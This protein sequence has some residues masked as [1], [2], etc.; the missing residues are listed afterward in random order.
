MA[1]YLGLSD[2]AASWQLQRN[3]TSIKTNLSEVGQKLTTG[4]FLTKDISDAGNIQKLFAIDNSLEILERYK[5]STDAGRVRLDGV[6][7]ILGQ[8]RDVAANVGLGV[9]TAVESATISTSLVEA[10][11]AGPA[12]QTIVGLLNTNVAGHSLFS[13]AASD[14]AALASSDQIQADIDA[15]VAAAPDVATA[16]ADIDFY[17]ND[18]TGGFETTIYT[19]SLIDA[20][21]IR[22]SETEVISVPIRADDQALRETLR[23]LSVFA[24][25]A[26]GGF[27][28]SPTQQEAMLLDAATRNLSASDD[29]IK[30]RE[31]TG[32]NQERLEE[33]T[34][35]NDAER[36]GLMISR[37]DIAN[38]DQY[39]MATMFQ[40]LQG[41][42]E[43][44]Y[45]ITARLSGLTLTNFLR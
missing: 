2:L 1:A 12:M 8:V 6:Q 24:A 39:E 28:G 9:L 33:A 41:Q 25:V 37:V 23:N 32:F 42:L 30:L 44:M 35:R 27:A 18:P 29:V 17:F 38:V 14:R 45:A 36:S 22:L 16:L 21:D 7:S 19:G 34:A 43:K 5:Q 31:S 3:N 20:P 13:G 26:N 10:R 11:G 40:E 15:I 4:E